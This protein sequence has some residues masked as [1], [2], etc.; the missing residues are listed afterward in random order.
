M[1]TARQFVQRY[2]GRAIAYDPGYGVQCVGGFKVFCNVEGIPVIACPNDWAESYWTCKDSSGNVVPSVYAW[3]TK[4]F[5]K[6]TNY[7]DFKNG[8]W[9][10]W[11]RGSSHPSS[12]IAMFYNGQE[13]GQRQY[14]D[15]RAFCLKDTNFTDALGALR[16]KGFENFVPIAYGKGIATINGHK[17]SYMR[18]ADGDQIAIIG[19]GLNKVAT[20][21]QLEESTNALV[22]GIVTGVCYFQMKE[23]QAD[24][25]GT[26]YGDISAPLSG[27]Y[28][29]L[30]NQDTTLFYDLETA[31]FGDCEYVDIDPAHNVFS[32]ALVFPNSKGHWEYA[33]M[34]GLTHKEYKSYYGFVVR[35][36]DGYAIGYNCEE[37]SPQEIAN[38]WNYTDMLNIAF[39]D[40][41]G[42]AQA[43]FRI[44]GEMKYERDTGRATPGAVI[45]Y[46][47]F[48]NQ[49]PIVIPDVPETGD[50]GQNNQNAAGSHENGSNSNGSEGGKEQ[51]MEDQK[52][53][54][55]VIIE[56]QEG[57]TD[58]EPSLGAT[59]IQR[60]GSLLS[61]KSLITLSLTGAFI[62][63]IINSK[64]LPEEFVHIY[65]M[66]ISFFFGYQFN[67]GGK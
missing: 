5:T 2:N 16:W 15:N 53:E 9:V 52:V 62:F 41:G 67:K 58:P 43:G 18:M 23:G 42:S 21:Q 38:D 7:K 20:I 4:Y 47:G 30:P 10:V 8:D 22:K 29:N 64:D 39:M 63:L 33:R 56:P 51:T 19:A 32:P 44:D 24:P 57:W 48:G 27:E 40:G 13:F 25:V 50:N 66:C 55:Q 11:G 14:E 46:Q 28:Q 6:I 34:V 31:L 3:Q 37:L 60:I 49:P 61:V 59:L 35:F 36:D 1:I 54:N 17:Y 26:T 65:T 12:H 45:I